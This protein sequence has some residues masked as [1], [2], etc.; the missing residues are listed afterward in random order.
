[1]IIAKKNSLGYSQHKAKKHLAKAASSET[2]S[3]LQCAGFCTSF[4][5]KLTAR[6]KGMGT[7][8]KA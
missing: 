6:H 1:M 5:Q 2:G 3:D 4:T 8:L 7:W